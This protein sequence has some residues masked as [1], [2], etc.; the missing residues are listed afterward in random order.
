MFCYMLLHLAACGVPYHFSSYGKNDAFQLRWIQTC[1]HWNSTNKFYQIS[2]KLEEKR[3]EKQSPHALVTKNLLLF[4]FCVSACKGDIEPARRSYTYTHT[5][6][7]TFFG[8]YV[9]CIML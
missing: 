6:G 5:N 4:F 2:G 9:S 3:T 8:R 1:A 7:I